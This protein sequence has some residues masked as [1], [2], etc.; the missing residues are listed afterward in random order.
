MNTF[1]LPRWRKPWQTK[2]GKTKQGFWQIRHNGTYVNLTKYGA[3]R[4]PG[5]KHVG[6]ACKAYE[7]FLVEQ[8]ADNPPEQELRVCDVLEPYVTERCPKIEVGENAAREVKAFLNGKVK[9]ERGVLAFPGVWDLPFSQR[10][11]KH[12]DR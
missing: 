6:A 12:F 2:D 4:L 1:N 10:N 8:E 11:Q 5:K 3:P 9:S 7:Q